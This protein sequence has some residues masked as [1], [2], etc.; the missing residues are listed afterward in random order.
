MFMCSYELSLHLGKMLSQSRGCDGWPIG[1]NG[2]PSH[3]RLRLCPAQ[4]SQTCH[5]LLA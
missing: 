3:L 4:C 2:E 1:A 5:R